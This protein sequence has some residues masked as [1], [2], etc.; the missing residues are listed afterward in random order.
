MQD[1]PKMSLL[2]EY[3]PKMSLPLRSTAFPTP[4]DH[5]QDG[6]RNHGKDALIGDQNDLGTV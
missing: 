4:V 1:Q 2:S 6:S 3:Q 5:R